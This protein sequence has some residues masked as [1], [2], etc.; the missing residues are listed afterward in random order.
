MKYNLL[1]EKWIPVLYK[2]GKGGICPRVNIIEAFTEASRIRE[3]AA[4]NPMDRL[5]ILR[6]LLALLYW[7]KGNPPDETDSI[8]SFPSDWFKTLDDNLDDNKDC[9]NLLGE[10]KRFY[11]DRT[12]KRTRPATVLIQ[13]VPAGNNF[14]H[15][16]HST[17]NESGLCLPCCAMGLLRLP[18]FAV[19][20]LSGPGEPNLMAGINGVPPLYVAPWGKSLLHT[21]LLNWTACANIGEPSWV[22]RGKSQNANTDVPL[23]AGLTLLPRRVFLH[24]PVAAHGACMGCGAGALPLVVTCEFQTAGKQE[25][26]RWTD[27]HAVYLGGEKRKAMRAAD[28]TASRRFRMDRPWPDLVARLLETGKPTTLL[29]VGFATHQAKNIDAWERTIEIPSTAAMPEAAAL[30][31]KWRVEARVME[32]KVEKIRRSE[33][34][35]AAFIAAVRPQVESRVSE[36]TRELISLGGDAWQEAAQEYRPLMAAVAKSLSPGYT[37]ASL[38]RR[39]EIAAVEPDMR[40]KTNR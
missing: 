35:G 6:F 19:S 9:F 4:S 18:L 24:D 10:R 40:P 12:A 13:E 1:E 3:I 7:C 23:L 32:K 33:A 15:L 39:Q 28:L 31:E 38:Q 11:Q 16:R 34:E 8:S 17:D 2:D 21:L 14:W 22:Q 36:M 30:V 25:N 26:D 27:P 20:G 29:I 5:A 37:T